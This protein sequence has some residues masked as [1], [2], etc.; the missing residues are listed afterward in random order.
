MF[1]HGYCYGGEEG[2]SG[3]NPNGTVATKKEAQDAI[4]QTLAG[5][6]VTFI[7]SSGKSRAYA[8]NVPTGYIY[9]KTDLELW[10]GLDEVSI[11]SKGEK[12]LFTKG[13]LA[14]VKAATRKFLD[15]E[16]TEY[17]D[18]SQPSV[19]TVYFDRTGDNIKVKVRYKG[20]HSTAS[21]DVTLIRVA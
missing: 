15:K 11:G 16:K 5:K 7:E 14:E 9:L 10:I 6:K 21:A 4:R 1:V 17:G 13:S 18:P 2:K 8:D 12:A 20:Q 3:F 19:E